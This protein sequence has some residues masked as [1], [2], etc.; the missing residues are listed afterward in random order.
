MVKTSQYIIF[1]AIL[2]FGTA[3]RKNADK[4]NKSAVFTV[5]DMAGHQVQIPLR[6][7]RIC[8]NGNSLNQLLLTLGA[9][10][11]IVATIPTVKSNP[12]F[13]R[14]YPQIKYTP[15]PFESNGDVNMET[16]LQCK[17]DL[18]ILWNEGNLATKLQS[19]GI[20]VL[21]VKFSTPDEFKKAV[22]LLGR[23]LGPQS[24]ATAKRFCQ[25]YDSL[26]NIVS[27]RLNHLPTSQRKRVYYS[28]DSPLSTEGQRSIV[29]SWIHD[30]GGTNVASQAGITAIRAEISAEKLL[31]QNPDIIIVRDVEN[32]NK[33]FTDPRFSQIKAVKQRQVWVNPKGVNVWSTRNG[34]SILQPLWAAKTFHPE[35]FK[36]INVEDELKLFYAQFYHYKLSQPEAHSIMEGLKYTWK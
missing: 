25:F 1:I 24:A 28:A 17:P 4:A 27:S 30:C 21:V 29:S 22:T 3:C 12:W 7:A 10:P 14:L 34:E 20:P 18:V 2:M 16:L 23:V 5:T 35:R 11:R 31:Q 32:K 8:S 26:Q 19:V 36:D 9:A 6:V 15:T 13:N 33:F